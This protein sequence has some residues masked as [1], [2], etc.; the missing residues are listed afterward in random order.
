[1]EVRPAKGELLKQFNTYQESVEFQ[2]SIAS[3][4]GSSRS[5]I[6]LDLQAPPVVPKQCFKVKTSLVI[7]EEPPTG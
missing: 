5:L 7:Q 1:M 2:K 3:Q 4:H 6:K